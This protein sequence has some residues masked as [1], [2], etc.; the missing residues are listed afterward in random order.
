MGR[1]HD[2]GAFDPVGEAPARTRAPQRPSSDA[3]A[4]AQEILDASSSA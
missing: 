3:F 1:A 2:V 4:Q